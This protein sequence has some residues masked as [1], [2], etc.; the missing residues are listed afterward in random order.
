VGGRK[1]RATVGL[2]TDK[3]ARFG[4]LYIGYLFR[5]VVIANKLPNRR[6]PSRVHG[7]VVLS[8]DWRHCLSHY[9]D[10]LIE[11]GLDALLLDIEEK[12]RTVFDMGDEFVEDLRLENISSTIASAYKGALRR[13]TIGRDGLVNPMPTSKDDDEAREEHDDASDEP[14]KIKS[15]KRRRVFG[16]TQTSNSAGS[17]IKIGWSGMG[18]DELASVDLHGGVITVV[19]NKNCAKLMALSQQPRW[20][21]LYLVIGAELSAH[22]DKLTLVEIEKAFGGMLGDSTGTEDKQAM[23]HQI[24]LWWAFVADDDDQEI[25]A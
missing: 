12:A 15:R 3:V 4:G 19:F 24:R 8:D 17:G 23:K 25:A 18:G 11:G 10:N 20:P 14:R 22:C 2:L 21:G 5:N 7:Q 16:P 6:Y 1:Y 9:K 13:S